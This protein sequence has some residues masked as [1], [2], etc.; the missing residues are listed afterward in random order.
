MAN[1]LPHVVIIGGG[2][3]GLSTA[4]ALKKA[5]VRVT[6]ID[7]RNHHLFQ[8][9]LY[10]VAS[11][12][13][14][15]ANI[16]APLR[17][18]LRKH[19]NVKVLLDEVRDI[20]LAGRR[21]LLAE[22]EMTYDTLVV[23]AGVTHQY[24]GH[25]E[26]EALAPG[27]KT[28]E[29]ATEMRRRILLAF[30]RAEFETDPAKR[31]ALLTFVVVGG[32]PT[33]V[34]LAGVI[35][36]LAQFTMRNDFRNIDTR[37]ARVL[38]LEGSPHILAAFP[39]ALSEQAVKQLASLGVTVHTHAHV[40]DVRPDG[41][42]VK[43]GERSEQ[44]P[45]RTVLWAA[46]VA[47]SPLGTL[48]AKAVNVQPDRCGRVPVEPD[49]TLPGHPEVFVIGD[50]AN[51]SHQGGKPL[52]GV[53][54]TAM[55]QGKYVARLIQSRLQGQATPPPFEYKDLGSMATIGRGR[56]IALLGNRQFK[57]YLAWLIWLFVHLMNIVHFENRVL[58]MIQWA[59]NYFTRNRSARLITGGQEAPAK[60]PE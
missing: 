30:E 32:G 29:D 8:P 37:D 50:L 54:P 40:S 16:A 27:L 59:G 45:T 28:I 20:D 43:M 31:D 24:F 6:L 51:F 55:Q 2:F 7:R 10:Q 15:P 14:S 44:I 4:Q 53:A 13:L 17:S 58:V 52:P 47:A 39:P 41:V 33:G 38:L 34:E 5:P 56:A 49:L 36:E 25:P 1:D 22:R 48:Q 35:G 3:G 19:Q 21:V 9:L 46:G 26:W 42:T 11:G 12:G 60:Q 18:V 23:A 57:G